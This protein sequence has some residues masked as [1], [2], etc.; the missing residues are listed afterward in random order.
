MSMVKQHLYEETYA[1]T[2]EDMQEYELYYYY[3]DMVE[4]YN[5]TDKPM[6]FIEEAFS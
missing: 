6:E 2:A 1:P 4:R 3:L 5:K